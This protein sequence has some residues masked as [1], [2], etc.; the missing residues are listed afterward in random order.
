MR[1]T[2]VLHSQSIA[3]SFASRSLLHGVLISMFHNIS[4]RQTVEQNTLSNVVSNNL[5]RV[6]SSAGSIETFSVRV[7]EEVLPVPVHAELYRQSLHDRG[8]LRDAPRTR[9]KQ[10][11]LLDGNVTEMQSETERCDHFNALQP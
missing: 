4:Q 5:F 1:G 10:A 9:L 6:F 2:C 11:M 3:W 7:Q 8:E